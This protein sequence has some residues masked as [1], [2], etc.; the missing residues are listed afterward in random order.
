MRK[1]KVE[2]YQN[3]YHRFTI[4]VNS[5][6]EVTFFHC[7][8]VHFDNPKCNRKLFKK[9][10]DQALEKEAYITITGDLMCLMQGKADRRHNKKNIRPEHLGDNYFDLVIE[11]TANFLEPYANNILLIS[12]GN[13]ETAVSGRIESDLMDR[14][15]FRLNA[16]AGSNV[17]KGPYTGYYNLNF[18]Y[19]KNRH[20]LIIGYSHGHWGGIVTKGTMS[21]MRYGFAMP[22]ADIVFSGHTHDGW[23]IPMPRMKLKQNKIK[24]QNQ[25]HVRTGTYKEEFACG[26]GWAAEKIGLPKY[27]GG[28][29]NTV[30]FNKKR[31]LDFNLTLTH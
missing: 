29:F 24:I 13:H 23:I 26:T 16:I 27:L 5:S 2:K 19:Q 25:W 11:D 14:L 8:D 9:H 22:D 30:R 4:P 10:L 21:A 7:S 3:N 28:C 15:V 6:D 18:Q 20:P 31:G 12:E 1:V 17:Q